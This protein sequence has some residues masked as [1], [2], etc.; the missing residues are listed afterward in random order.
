[1]LPV[2]AH[3]VTEALLRQACD[4]AWPESSTLDFKAILPGSGGDEL[5]EFRKDVCAFANSDGGD[6]VFGISD[7]GGRAGSIVPIVAVQFDAVRRRLRQALD[8]RVE[9]RIH[10]VQI[11]ECPISSGGFAVIVRIPASFHGPH[12]CGPPGTQ[13]FVLRNDTGTSDMSYDQLRSAFDRG[14]TLI[15]K[16]RDFCARRV[17]DINHGRTPL[18]IEQNPTAIVHVVPLGGLSGRAGVDVAALRANNQSLRLKPDDHWQA[19]VNFEGLLLY[20][21]DEPQR[22]PISYLQVFRNGAIEAVEVVSYEPQRGPVAVVGK[23]AAELLQNGITA[24]NRTAQQLNLSGAAIVSMA[25]IRATGTVLATGEHAYT[26]TPMAKDV[27]EFPEGWIE[28]V[29]ASLDVHGLARP[30]MD[31]LYQTYGVPRF[32]LFDQKGPSTFQ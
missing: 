14:A 23:F 12:R 22:P 27:F 29:S 32:D 15:E 1:M 17:E 19:R 2:A 24:F 21:Y 20:P 6:I 28:D 16:A 25:L 18:T 4:D 5:D 31:V 26:R 10:A 11:H 3:Q 7:A 30:I 13:R 8:A 9:P